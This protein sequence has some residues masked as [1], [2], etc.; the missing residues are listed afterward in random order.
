MKADLDSYRMIYGDSRKWLRNGWCDYFSPQ[1]YWPIRGDQSFS[2]LLSWWDGENV[3]GRHVWPGI[4]SDRVGARL[5][6]LL[7]ACE[8]SER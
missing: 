7:E 2:S 6:R 4:A 5:V 3:R 1:L 8:G